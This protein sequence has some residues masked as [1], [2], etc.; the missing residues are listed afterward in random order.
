MVYLFPSVLH[1]DSGQEAYEV[2]NMGS[3]KTEN[4][5]EDAIDKKMKHTRIRGCLSRIQD[6]TK[7]SHVFSPLDFII[8]I[9]DF[10]LSLIPKPM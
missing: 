2:W 5:A 4:T 7:H 9:S 6:N 8:L 3:D 1:L 10:D